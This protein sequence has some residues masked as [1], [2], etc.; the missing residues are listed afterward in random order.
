MDTA[1]L[2]CWIV[3]NSVPYH[4]ARA[5]AAVMSARVRI[6]MVQLTELDSF[7]VLEQPRSSTSFSR[8]TLF[9]ETPWD[10]I[11]G[12]DMV[13]RLRAC[14]DEI[15]PT[16]VCIN[17]WSLGGGIAALEWCLS[18]KVPVVVMSESTEMDA[19]RTWWVEAVKRRVVKLCSAAL[20]GGTPHQQ[21]M[22]ALGAKAERIFTGYDAVD[23]EHFR[24]GAAA[25]RRRDA[26]L[27]AMLALPSRYFMACAR[28]TAKK[29]L[30]GLLSAYAE[31]RRLH[32]QAAW[33]LVIIGDGEQKEELLLARDRLRLGND[34]LLPGPKTYQ[35][36]PAYYGLASAFVHASTT[37][38]WGLVVNEAMASGLP[39]LVSNRCGCA[40]DLVRQG[41]NG[42][43][44]DPYD[45]HQMAAAM[46]SVAAGTHDREKMGQASQQ[47]IAHWSPERFAE[48]LARATETALGAAR[49]RAGIMD[50]MLLRML[51]TR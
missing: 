19:E 43:L 18:H 12:R 49:P 15:K 50:R 33:S 44:F 5:T 35:Q 8:L 16:I 1:P 26:A 27:R 6:C 47:I 22:T 40:F 14:L 32:E 39:V 45:T 21:Y 42:L 23:N 9:P 29:N 20:V 24:S 31:Y 38:Q 30:L 46:L 36:L 4:E 41:R 10:R 51:S 48:G 25:A 7:R 13:L 11:G 2:V 17:G 37:E 3:V 28:Y 34:V